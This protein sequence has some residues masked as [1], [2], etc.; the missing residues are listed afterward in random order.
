MEE[1]EKKIMR[2]E[3]I[4]P[5]IKD[6]MQK[7]LD[8]QESFSLLKLEKEHS[9]EFRKDFEQNVEKLFY[10]LLQEERF[11]KSI[12]KYIENYLEKKSSQEVFNIQVN[13]IVEAKWKELQLGFFWKIVGVLGVVWGA[14]VTIMLRKYL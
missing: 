13:K 3:I 12:E 1:L 6:S 7:I 8:T 10:R 14:I 5:Q 9:Q 11:E 2:F 4:L